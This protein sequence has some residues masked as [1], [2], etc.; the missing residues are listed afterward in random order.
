[1]NAAALQQAIYNALNVSG[2][3]SLL[4]TAHDLS[5]AIFSNVEQPSDGEDPSYFPYIVIGNDVIARWDTKDN[6]GGDAR[7]QISIFDRSTSDIQHRAV[8]DAVD[9]AL[10][11]QALTI[12][13]ATHITTELENA[14]FS[15]D[16]D[17]ITTQWIALYNII[18]L[19]Q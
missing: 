12:P 19:E 6:V 3:T 15:R 8:V 1:M 13:G 16:P 10:R 14:T 11:R 9:T 7:V 5:P 2:V 4:S 18:W 17:G